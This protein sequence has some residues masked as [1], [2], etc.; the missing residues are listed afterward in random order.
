M[1][2]LGSNQSAI[3]DQGYYFAL[4][5]QVD[6]LQAEITAL[7]IASAVVPFVQTIGHVATWASSDSFPPPIG[8]ERNALLD[9]EVL[10]DPVG[11]IEFV[12]SIQFHGF[13]GYT[14]GTGYTGITGG[15]GGT[16]LASDGNNLYW[17]GNLIGATGFAGPTG[18]TGHIGLTGPTGP[19]ALS[20]YSIAT[21][22][23]TSGFSPDMTTSGYTP[24]DNITSPLFVSSDSNLTSPTGGVIKWNGATGT[25][26]TISVTINYS[27]PVQ[28]D[29]IFLSLYSLT[30]SSTI[31][32][33][34][35]DYVIQASVGVSQSITSF[36]YNFGH[37]EQ[38]TFALKT[39]S[40]NGMLSGLSYTFTVV[41]DQAI[42]GP[43][44]SIGPT[45]PNLPISMAGYFSEQYS[46]TIST[47]TLL[48]PNSPARTPIFTTNS[49]NLSN[50][51]A[52]VIQW[53]G[54]D[55]TVGTITATVSISGSAD[56][57][58]LAIASSPSFNT[59]IL[60]S[61]NLGAQVK[62]AATTFYLVSF[63]FTHSF[64]SGEGIG[65]LA[66]VLSG[67]NSMTIETL[68]LSVIM[69]TP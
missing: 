19:G 17:N 12:N 11:N 69:S 9:S 2:N 38:V 20:N 4:N 43:T 28:G 26:G 6:Q 51:S 22:Y 60:Y 53:N 68:N 3:S 66:S 24:V 49:S 13:T 41:M 32:A 29:N 61:Y 56:T 39:T 16:G 55:S 58:Y 5:D 54:S 10:I 52:G 14:G 33:A 37:N 65:V 8:S 34:N 30:N 1:S 40:T 67:S 42:Q 36:G 27:F 44:G 64:A 31:G 50:P 59:P 48:V 15:A 46:Q 21:S 25:Y 35:Q 47:N 45:G 18:P 57:L 7:Q 23:T 62:I 63:T